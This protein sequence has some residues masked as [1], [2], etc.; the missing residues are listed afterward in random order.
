MVYELLIAVV[1]L[2]VEHRLCGT[3]ASVVVA[4]GLEST[5]SVVVTQGLS[6]SSASGIFLDQGW[7]PCPLHWQVDS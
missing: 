4:C 6:C 2:V 5:G 7:N 3:W 1:S